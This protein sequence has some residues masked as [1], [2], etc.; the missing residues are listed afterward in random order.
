[1][2]HSVY[3]SREMLGIGRLHSA[4]TRIDCSRINGCLLPYY[5]FTTNKECFL[6]VVCGWLLIIFCVQQWF[7]KDLKAYLNPVNCPL[8]LSHET[9]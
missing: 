8:I 1:M 7:P 9:V 5:I 4:V 3:S 2:H 6:V